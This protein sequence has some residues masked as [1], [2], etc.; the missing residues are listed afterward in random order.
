MTADPAAPP[1]RLRVMFMVGSLT[2]GGAER[3][4]ANVMNHIDRRR[5]EP[6]LALYR[7]DRSYA[8]PDDV[9]VKVLGKYKPWQNL[10]AAIRFARWIDQVR[11]DVVLSAWSVPNV[12]TAETLRLARHRPAWIARIASNPAAEERGAYGLWARHSYARAQS[13]VA[14]CSAL[15]EAFEAAYPF[16]SRRVRVVYNGVDVH[17]LDRLAASAPV[18]RAAMGPTQ[19]VAVGRLH[20]DKRFDILL[21]SLARALPRAP[22]HL[23]LLGD[24]KEKATLERLAGNLGIQHAVTWHGFVDNPYPIYAASDVFVLTSDYEGLSNAL[25]ESQALGLPA[26]ATDCPFGN[27]EVI[28]HGYN[29]LLAPTG[30]VDAIAAHLWKLATDRQQRIDMGR[31]ARARIAE[32]FSLQ[33]MIAELESVLASAVL[34]PEGEHVGARH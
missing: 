5:F 21:R 23:H 7:R 14:V 12:F 4:V 15:A 22:M 6:F 31:N 33:S 25:L 19:L 26:V 1:N 9:P 3:F 32:R 27:A 11:P 16:A 30:D 28:E 29:G 2:T 24:G 20:Q 10:L 17:A 8:I 13:F 18:A 34:G